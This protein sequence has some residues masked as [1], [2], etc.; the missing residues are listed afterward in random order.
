MIFYNSLSKLTAQQQN[1][2]ITI[3]YIIAVTQPHSSWDLG[4]EKTSFQIHCGCLVVLW[5]FIP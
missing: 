4:G 5:E 3:T 1:C 2:S